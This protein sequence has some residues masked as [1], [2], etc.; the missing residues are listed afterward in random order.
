MLGPICDGT[1]RML[2]FRLRS[3]AS[4]PR[5]LSV[6]SV[7]TEVCSALLEVVILRIN[8]NSHQLGGICKGV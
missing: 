6:A 8:L 2:A 1:M 7:D 3:V 5:D 4:Q